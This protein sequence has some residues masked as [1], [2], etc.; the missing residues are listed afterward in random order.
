LVWFLSWE[1]KPHQIVI[2]FLWKD[3]IRVRWGVNGCLRNV[4][5]GEVP[6]H[7]S[8]IWDIPVLKVY[9]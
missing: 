2:D 3:Q 1:Y 5:T 7:V 8:I 9:I 6:S 4:V